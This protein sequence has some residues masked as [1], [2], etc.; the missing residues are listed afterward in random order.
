MTQPLFKPGKKGKPIIHAAINTLPHLPHEVVL[1]ITL[2]PP[3]VC[4]SLLIISFLF[5]TSTRAHNIG[6]ASPAHLHPSLDVTWT[7]HIAS[8]QGG[9]QRNRSF[10]SSSNHSRATTGKSCEEITWRSS[11]DDTAKKTPRPGI[12]RTSWIALAFAWG[13]QQQKK[14]RALS[15]PSFLLDSPTP[16]AV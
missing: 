13:A 16:A 7:F 1:K 9:T 14:E 12:L 4:F 11:D 15:Q 8:N 10:Y 6:C 3:C 5:V 2:Q